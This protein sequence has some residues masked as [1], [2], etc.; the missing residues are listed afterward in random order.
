ME[1]LVPIAEIFYVDFIAR[2]SFWM[3]FSR[4]RS[5]RRHCSDP[6]ANTNDSAENINNLYD[7]ERITRAGKFSFFRT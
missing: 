6:F 1:F 3:K 4:Q 7:K 2:K 5:E